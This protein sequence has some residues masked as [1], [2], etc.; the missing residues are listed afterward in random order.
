VHVHNNNSSNNNNN[1]NNN[2]R[3]YIAPYGRNFI[4]AAVYFKV[5]NTNY[6]QVNAF[7]DYLSFG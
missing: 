3:I 5:K 2:S 1:N 7:S 4:G 6:F